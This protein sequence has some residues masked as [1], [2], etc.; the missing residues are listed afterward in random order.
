M[1]N[2]EGKC[3]SHQSANFCELDQEASVW[4]A[5]DPVVACA[6]DDR[7]AMPLAVTMLTAARSLPPGTRLRLFVLDGGLSEEN[8]HRL[9]AS[10]RNEPIELNWLQPDP[11]QVA[12]LKTSHHISPVA[13]YR[14][15]LPLVLPETLQRVLYL[16]CDLLIRDDLTQLWCQPLADHWC[17]AIPDVACPNVDARRGMSNFRRACPYLASLRPIP[18]YQDFDIDPHAPYFNSGVLLINLDAWRREGL[19]AN[20]LECLRQHERHVWCWDQYALNIALAGHWRPLSLRW[21]VGTHVFEY[22]TLDHAPVQRDQF[23]AALEDPAIVH[24][25]TEFK[26]WNYGIDHPYRS[27]FF[28]ILDQT[29]WAGWRPTKP[30]FRLKQWWDRRAVAI[31]KQ[32]V[33]AYRKMMA[34]RYPG[35]YTSGCQ[36]VEV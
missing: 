32:A 20:M 31:Q 12:G 14:I 25:T 16:D 21:N 9:E 8:R 35:L 29:A 36:H 18:N 23:A 22:P 7:Y 11:N 24:F 3:A 30:P 10:W 15:L 1:V 28:D 26:P 13:Y 5:T 34:V 33:I 4:P 17:L 6:T 19:P 2:Q 27:A